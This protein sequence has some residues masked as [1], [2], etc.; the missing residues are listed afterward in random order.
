MLCDNAWLPQSMPAVALCMSSTLLSSVLPNVV[1]VTLQGHVVAW[2][3]N[4]A[5]Q[6]RR[7]SVLSS[8][9]TNRIRPEQHKIHKV[10]QG[11]M[12][13][14]PGEA[15]LGFGQVQLLQDSLIWPHCVVHCLRGSCCSRGWGWGSRQGW[16]FCHA[17]GLCHF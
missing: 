3:T 4:T 7:R 5:S 1:D 15:G 11:D 8:V 10:Q 16:R 2:C 6:V 9:L 14:Y 13:G 17:A 12:R